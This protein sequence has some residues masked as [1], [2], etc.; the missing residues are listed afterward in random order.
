MDPLAAFDAMIASLERQGAAARK[1][2][3]TLV[4]LRAELRRDEQKYRAR[5]G[6][7]E[8]R[9]SGD[10][11][12]RSVMLRDA[13]EARGL[14]ARTEEALAQAEADA[15]VLLATAE[16]LSRQLAELKEERQSARARFAGGVQVSAALK[17][18]AADFEQVM[19]LDA[20]RDEIE[21]ARALAELYREEASR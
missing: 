12:V 7:L 1:A 19:K 21:R 14:L 15:T 6:E 2:A 10:P 16:A 17:A 4:A 9:E 3:A 11:R 5:L 8:A 20:A 13:A 18:R